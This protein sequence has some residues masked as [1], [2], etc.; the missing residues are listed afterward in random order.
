MVKNL[1]EKYA[2]F[3]SYHPLSVLIIVL[4][5]SGVAVSGVL[6]LKTVDMDYKDMLPE[7]VEVIDTMDLVNEQFGGVNT[8]MIVIDVD[9]HY[10]KSDEIRDVRDPRVL[11]YADLLAK[12]ALTVDDVIDATSAADIF[13]KMNDS[14]IPSSIAVIK[15]LS[16]DNFFVNSYISKDYATTLVK[17]KLDE[18]VDKTEAEK[19]LQQVID[20]TP[21]PAGVSVIL[22]GETMMMP[23]MLRLIKPDMARTSRASLIGILVIV[24]IL[25]GSVRYGLTPLATILFGVVW[26]MGFIGLIGLG[27]SPVTSAVISMIMGIGIDF[28]IQVV[29]RF[30]HELKS[31][32][33][34]KAMEVT[35]S[36][37]FM[38]MTITTLA[39][40][41]GFKAMSWGKLTMMG[42]MGKMMSYGVLACMLVAISLIPALLILGEKFN[43]KKIKS[44]LKEV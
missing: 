21:K 42:D 28:G 39:A 8:A 25:F 12:K 1:I 44:I 16:K 11:R 23:V 41:I 29:T 22:S 7:G 15:N 26:A 9:P 18:D 2:R 37:V 38:P 10:A 27:I 17:I 24:L 30:M 5:I 35:L 36:N 3:V 13:K 32:D 33:V 31:Y 19:E 14:H 20:E 34:H 6:M 43:L 40:I 4:L